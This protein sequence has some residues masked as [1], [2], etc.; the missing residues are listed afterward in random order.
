[1]SIPQIDDVAARVQRVELFTEEDGREV[2]VLRTGRWRH[3]GVPVDALADE[4]LRTRIAVLAASL[5]ADQVDA[6][7]WARLATPR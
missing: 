4:A 5:P 3:L 6:P 7:S 1:M 2:L